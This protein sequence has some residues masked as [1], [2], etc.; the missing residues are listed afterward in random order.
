MKTDETTGSKNLKVEIISQKDFDAMNDERKLFFLDL[1]K[2]GQV[3]IGNGLPGKDKEEKPGL[4]FSPF[5]RL[6][7]QKV[8][9]GLVTFE[10]L[11]GVLESVWQYEILLQLPD[12]RIMTV[13]KHSIVTLV[14]ELPC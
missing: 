13:L 14:G 3:K 2:K 9:I 8:I 11:T 7:G 6:V 10:E 4:P 12:G 1:I 5:N